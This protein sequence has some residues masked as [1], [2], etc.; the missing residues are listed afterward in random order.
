ML[1][2]KKSQVIKNLSE[3]KLHCICITLLLQRPKWFKRPSEKGNKRRLKSHY[4][5]SFFK[6]NVSS[7]KTTAN[8]FPCQPLNVSHHAEQ[9]ANNGWLLL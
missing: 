9:V 3:D 5:L 8:F 4:N 2:Q 1:L 6:T 7:G